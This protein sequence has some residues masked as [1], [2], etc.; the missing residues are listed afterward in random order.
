MPVYTYQP[1]A[2]YYNDVS[3]K[4]N[5][6]IDIQGNEYFRIQWNS[7]TEYNRFRNFG[8][9]FKYITITPIST[10]SSALSWKTSNFHTFNNDL[11]CEIEVL[12]HSVI[13]PWQNGTPCSLI[14]SPT[15]TTDGSPSVKKINTT[16]LVVIG[17][18]VAV[19][20]VVVI[21]IVIIIIAA[22]AKRRPKL[23]IR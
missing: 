9:T 20:V 12:G 4:A 21:V 1:F 22:L 6:R 13:V 2:V 5:L 18:V 17:I 7:P 16:A 15:K 8:G 14:L 10:P 23:N 3:N 19:V 11:A